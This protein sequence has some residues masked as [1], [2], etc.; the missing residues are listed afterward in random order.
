V[1][2][3]NI[4]IWGLGLGSVAVLGVAYALSKNGLAGAKAREAEALKLRDEAVTNVNAWKG[5]EAA[6]SK[7]PEGAQAW[8]ENLH[9]AELE[10]LEMNKRLDAAAYEVNKL[11][12]L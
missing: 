6:E 5:R 8:K 10:A 7:T 1:R 11:S 3:N 9:L 2:N 4:L 12:G